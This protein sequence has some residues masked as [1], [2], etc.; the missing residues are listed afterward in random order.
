MSVKSSRF[1]S[2]ATTTAC[3]AMALA[4]ATPAQAIVPNDN[5]TPADIIDDTGFNGVGMFFRNDGFVCSGT[6]LNP[7][8][9]LFAAHCV[10][11]RPESDYGT[12]IRSAFSFDD[13]ALPGFLDWINNGFR[14]SN[15][16]GV[17]DIAQ[18]FYDPRSLDDPAAQGFLEGDIAIASLSSPVGT[19]LDPTTQTL[20]PIIPTWALLFSP[21]PAP[22]S[23]DPVTGT[24][25]HVNITGYGRSGNG[26]QG[27]IQG[28]DWR[29][30]AAENM[31][32]ALTSFDERNQFLFGDPFG[33]LPSS[34]YRLDFDDPNKTNPFDFNLY[35]DEPLEREATTA[36]GDSGGPLVLDAAN[37]DLSDEDLQIGVLSGGSRFFGPQ[38]FSSYGT[39]SFYQPLYLYWDYIIATNPYRYV[40]A[41][42]GDGNWE[43]GSHWVTELDPIYR[44]IDDDG[45]VVNGL[46]TSPGL[47]PEGGSP[48]FGEVCFDPE[49]ANPGDG[50]QDLETGDA[51]PPARETGG[52][53]VSGIGT[54]NLDDLVNPAVAADSGDEGETVAANAAPAAGAEAP[55]S[56]P[57]VRAGMIMG[58]E[59]QSQNG[60]EFAIE[61][62]HNGV[63]LV[64]NQPHDE[65]GAE[66][67]EEQPQG[68]NG[69]GPEFADTPNP[70]P[71]LDNGL[72]GATGF[73]PDNIDADAVAGVNG[74]YFD[75]T[76]SAAGTTTLSS[77]VTIDRL[78]VTGDAGLN[79]ASTGDLSTV[80]DITQ[81]GG[82]INVDGS[83]NTLGDFLQVA[84]LL[85]GTGTVQTPFLTSVMGGIAPGGMGTVGTLTVDGNLILSSGATTMFDIGD[86]PTSDLLAVT[87]AANLGGTIA[88]A[89][90]A[91]TTPREGDIYTLITAGGGVTGTF[92]TVGTIS[93]ILRADVA[94]NANDVRIRIFASDFADIVDGSSLVQTS[95]ANI[96]DGN[97][98]RADL[99]AIYDFLDLA[100]VATIQATFEGLAPLNENT[101]TGLGIAAIDH[102][103]RFYRDR[104]S[105]LRGSGYGGGGTISM[106]G[107]PVQVAALADNGASAAPWQQQVAQD[108]NGGGQVVDNT[109][110]DDSMAIFLAGGF[111]DGSLS[112][113]PA[114][115]ATGRD[116]FDGYFLAGGLEYMPHAN[117]VIGISIAYT[118][119][120][121]DASAGQTANGELL[122]GTI[123]GS[124]TTASNFVLSGQTSIGQ[125]DSSSRRTATVGPVTNNLALDEDVFSFSTEGMV[126]YNIHSGNFTLTPNVALRYAIL[127]FD[128]ANETGGPLALAIQRRTES[129]DSFQGRFGFDLGF[130]SANIRPRLNMAY[131]HDFSENPA[132]FTANLVG[133]PNTGIAPFALSAGQDRDWVEVSAGLVIETG[134]IDIDLAADTTVWRSDVRNQSYRATATFRF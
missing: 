123:Y 40:S 134:S 15:D 90:V 66:F 68:I 131:V 119:L 51:T 30:R 82:M 73:V 47:G 124:W 80:I 128:N 17:Y 18:V 112:P 25:Y 22:D 7:R 104:M 21:L 125:L 33:D 36:G 111:I 96:F 35:K 94:Y 63:E 6:L 26:T 39:E 12:V 129:V 70:A 118:D 83:L 97:R 45:N 67:A 93:A 102:M 120:D 57:G 89:P 87:R 101:R 122:Q 106:V 110:I 76:L 34:L 53:I 3:G 16:L 46:P 29:R 121:G 37:N 58:A 86:A 48:D 108:A 74:R 115:L 85:T 75:V 27:D 60:V 13:D 78:T 65:D 38:S 100:D 99:S 10:N 127:D 42:E 114:A 126:G 116:Q 107:N 88:F 59:N 8:T 95:Y 133:G 9:V 44:I 103:S 61:A 31:L 109:S 79:V 72:P 64:E 4:L 81:T 69:G 62:P 56:A 20:Q 24:G 28:I 55:A 32:G 105:A 113:M 11:D 23:I 50:C 2:L 43:D 1:L 49:G 41:V 71:T 117:A 98:G 5:F 91:G 52:N 84:G 19:R 132:L 130:G 77:A 14:S 92:D 54:A